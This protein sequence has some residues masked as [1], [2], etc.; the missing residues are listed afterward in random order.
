MRQDTLSV[1]ILNV[2]ADTRLLKL[3]GK[4]EM[5]ETDAMIDFSCVAKSGSLG[6]MILSKIEG[7]V[8]TWNILMIGFYHWENLKNYSIV[9]V[10]FIEQP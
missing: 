10:N 7:K 1:K 5:R 6:P 4:N 3:D 2:L 8:S 9:I